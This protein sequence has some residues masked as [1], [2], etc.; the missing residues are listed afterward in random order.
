M[1]TCVLGATRV[2]TVWLSASTVY[3]TAPLSA[4]IAE[5]NKREKERAARTVDEQVDAGLEGGELRGGEGDCWGRLRL[6]LRLLA[7]LLLGLCGIW[8]GESWD[9]HVE[10]D[11]HLAQDKRRRRERSPCNNDPTWL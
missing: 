7:L 2:C 5:T 10:V 8:G 4:S 9:G 3:P 6:C 11:V 1:F